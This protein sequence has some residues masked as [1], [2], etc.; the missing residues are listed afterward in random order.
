MNHTPNAPSG[1]AVTFSD[2]SVLHTLSGAQAGHL[3]H[4][5]AADAGRVRDA[6]AA[7]VA[8][9]GTVVLVA[10]GAA[11]RY[12]RAAFAWPPEPGVDAAPVLLCARGRPACRALDDLLAAY[13]AA[14]RPPAP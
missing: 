14:C 13:R 3:A 10:G 11:G 1:S 5:D 12:A 7:A 9:P 2:G 4:G 8:R 6:L